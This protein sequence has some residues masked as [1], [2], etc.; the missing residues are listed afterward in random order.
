M[1]D[2]VIS[3][4][5]H[6]DKLLSFVLVNNSVKITPT[7]HSFD[8]LC[9]CRVVNMTCV[10]Y[11]LQN[12]GI[13][14]PA[15]KNF[16]IKLVDKDVRLLLT[17]TLNTRASDLDLGPCLNVWSIIVSREPYYKIDFLRTY[18]DIINLL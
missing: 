16:H 8:W 11:I 18:Q 10:C 3:K 7:L 13:D 1:N 17:D 12:Y 15:T 2:M 4:Y 9:S 6:N 14:Y 5:I